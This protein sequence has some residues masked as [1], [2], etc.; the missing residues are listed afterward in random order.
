MT[1]RLKKDAKR[2]E[3]EKNKDHFDSFHKKPTMKQ[4]KYSVLNEPQNLCNISMRLHKTLPVIN[5]QNSLFQN[6]KNSDSQKQQ[7]FLTKN[8]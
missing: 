1:K 3:K 8:L 6:K 5:C 7:K 4:S 2:V